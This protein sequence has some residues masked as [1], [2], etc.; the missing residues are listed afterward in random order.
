M[1]RPVRI[2]FEGGLYHVT[3]RGDHQEAIYTDDEGGERFFTMIGDATEAHRYICHGYCLM[4]N[5][6]HII[7]E[8]P[9]GS[10]S[11]ARGSLTVCVQASIL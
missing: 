4:S 3:S 10:L 7:I 2:E 1:T 6:Y 11:K 9:N 8:T 5:Y